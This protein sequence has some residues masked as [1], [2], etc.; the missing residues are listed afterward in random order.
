MHPDEIREILITAQHDHLM[1]IG[2]WATLITTEYGV[3][4]FVQE[5]LPAEW[6]VIVCIEIRAYLDGLLVAGHTF[7]IK[8]RDV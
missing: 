1:A 5:S 8:V 2:K 4:D 6:P 3:V 7:D